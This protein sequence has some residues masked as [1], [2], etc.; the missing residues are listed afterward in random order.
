MR[1]PLSSPGAPPPEWTPIDIETVFDPDDGQDLDL[2]GGVINGE[3]S[4]VE[5]N[6][7]VQQWIEHNAELAEANLSAEGE[8]LVSILEREGQRAIAVLEGIQ[9][10]G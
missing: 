3:L 7:T 8:R 1:P 2:F 5:R 9:T 10:F 6:M 4:D